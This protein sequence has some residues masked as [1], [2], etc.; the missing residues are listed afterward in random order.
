MTVW[1]GGCV[2]VL[3]AISVLPLKPEQQKY[4]HYITI[5]IVKFLWGFSPVITTTLVNSYAFPWL[6]TQSPSV[7]CRAEAEAAIRVQ[8]FD[9]RSEASCLGVWAG[10]GT[11]G[12]RV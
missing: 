9:V 4:Y 10:A 2:S 1:V 7:L 11:D 8:V 12:G 6:V 3:C 5:V